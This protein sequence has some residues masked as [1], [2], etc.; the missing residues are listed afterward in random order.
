MKRYSQEV[1]CITDEE[2]RWICVHYIVMGGHTSTKTKT[3]RAQRPSHPN[4]KKIL[5]SNPQKTHTYFLTQPTQ[6]NPNPSPQAAAPAPGASDG[7]LAR[8]RRKWAAWRLT[9]GSEY[10]DLPPR[11]RNRW[12]RYDGVLRVG[13]AGCGCSCWGCLRCVALP[14]L[15]LLTGLAN[16]PPQN[17]PKRKYKRKNKQTNKQVYNSLQRA[18]HRP[19]RPRRAP[20]CEGGGRRVAWWSLYPSSRHQIVH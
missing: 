7:P 8:L 4:P 2:G 13:V 12:R 17:S 6:T 14:C 3:K 16:Y 10:K 11:L 19:L 15:A 20:A 18:F 9:A 5:T 1:G